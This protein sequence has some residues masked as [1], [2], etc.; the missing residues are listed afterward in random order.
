MK[1]LAWL[2]LVAALPGFI[3][4]LSTHTLKLVA[5]FSMTPSWG[6][7][8]TNASTVPRYASAIRGDLL[9][10]MNES[11]SASSSSFRAIAFSRVC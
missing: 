9:D 10:A 4:D 11:A 3:P 5:A 7:L 6:S 8:R 1:L 2:R